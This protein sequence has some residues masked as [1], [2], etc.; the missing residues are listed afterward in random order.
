MALI[1]KNSVDN[2]F[3]SLIN[4]CICKNYISCFTTQFEC[5]F[6]IGSCQRALNNFSY[7]G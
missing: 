5:V 3:D 2:S 6:F 1:E 7:F 4:C